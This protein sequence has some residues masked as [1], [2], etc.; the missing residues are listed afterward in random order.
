MPVMARGAAGRRG[1]SVVVAVMT[2]NLFQEAEGKR[3]YRRGRSIFF[4]GAGGDPEERW[5]LVAEKVGKQREVVP[6]EKIE[7][8]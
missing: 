5:G 4:R 1:I 7:E 6:A 2:R 3:I 8:S